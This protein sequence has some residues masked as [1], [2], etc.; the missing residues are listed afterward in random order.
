MIEYLWKASEGGGRGQRRS[1]K[2][3]D[4]ARWGE[5]GR[6]RTWHMEDVHLGASWADLQLRV[7]PFVHHLLAPR[8]VRVRARYG[9]IWGDMKRCRDM[10][11]DMG[12]SHLLAPWVVR[13]RIAPFDVGVRC[14]YAKRERAPHDHALRPAPQPRAVCS[15]LPTAGGVCSALPSTHMPRGSPR[16]T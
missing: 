10:R 2:Q 8:V 6:A 1:W 15:V 5:I 13:I 9:E 3:G 14:G 4:V 12:R 7:P 16:C 11:R